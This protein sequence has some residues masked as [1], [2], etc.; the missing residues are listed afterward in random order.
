MSQ[1]DRAWVESLEW[2]ADDLVESYRSRRER[3]KHRVLLDLARKQY[4]ER[5]RF[6]ESYRQHLASPKW[7]ALRE[8]VMKR[9]SRTCE[10]CGSRPAVDVHHLTYRH[11]MAEFLFELVGLCKECHERWHQH[12]ENDERADAN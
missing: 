5:G 9:C 3:E 2:L 7:H 4:A 12:D 8:K 11:F 10:G 1:K 6:T